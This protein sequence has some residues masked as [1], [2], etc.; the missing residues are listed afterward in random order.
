MNLQSIDRWHQTRTGHL[1]FGL[2]ELGLAYAFASLAIN[3]GSLWQYALAIISLVGAIQN[4]VRIFRP[5]N[6]EH[7]KR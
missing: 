4:F 5:I 2:G 3:S 7:S 1:I 6:N